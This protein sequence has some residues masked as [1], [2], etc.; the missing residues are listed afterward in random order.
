MNVSTSLHH[1]LGFIFASYL[2]RLC[3]KKREKQKKAGDD[4][5]DDRSHSSKK[6]NF[7]KGRKKEES[8]YLSVPFV[9]KENTSTLTQVS[10]NSHWSELDYIIS[11]SWRRQE[12]CLLQRENVFMTE[13]DQL[14]FAAW[15]CTHCRGCWHQGADGG[16]HSADNWHLCPIRWPP[17][18]FSP[19][20]SVSSSPFCL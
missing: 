19:L 8:S 17:S 5:D 7:N 14:W 15:D 13:F 12:K 3:L 2:T 4:T 11:P 6:Q 10:L 18:T 20:C 9:W 1:V 16:G